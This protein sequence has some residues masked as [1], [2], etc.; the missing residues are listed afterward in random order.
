MGD[1]SQC[2]LISAEQLNTSHTRMDL[3]RDQLKAIDIDA[4]PE[5]FPEG[6]DHL[7]LFNYEEAA[8][9]PLI[10]LDAGEE[11]GR[12]KF[13]PGLSQFEDERAK[14]KVM[15]CAYEMMDKAKT[16]YLQ[17]AHTYNL[18]EKIQLINGFKWYNSPA[19]LFCLS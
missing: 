15:G 19:F 5:S 6:K 4:L 8:A 3:I 18:A 10:Q 2:K 12:F 14:Q 7:K 9:T 17:N 1:L 11:V 13:L 16:H